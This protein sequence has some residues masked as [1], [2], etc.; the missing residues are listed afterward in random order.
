VQEKV[1]CERIIGPRAVH[2]DMG[3]KLVG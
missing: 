3:K 2:F 1:A